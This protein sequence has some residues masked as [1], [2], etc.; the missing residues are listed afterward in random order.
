MRDYS[1]LHLD[2]NSSKGIVFHSH[3]RV[4]SNAQTSHPKMSEYVYRVQS[5]WKWIV[6]SCLVQIY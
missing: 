1:T 4:F 6:M 5:F 2:I 3:S